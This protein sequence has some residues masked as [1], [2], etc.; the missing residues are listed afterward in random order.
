MLATV[1]RPIHG[2]R[3]V[4]PANSV[5]L[6]DAPIEA[7]K[8]QTKLNRNLT[9]FTKNSPRWNIYLNFKHQLQYFQKENI[10]EKSVCPCV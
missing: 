8:K 7:N 9:S 1:K 3:I 2:E 4:F 6:T 10:R 5:G